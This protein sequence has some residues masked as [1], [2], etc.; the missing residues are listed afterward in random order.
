M[1]A[2]SS[3]HGN[4]QYPLP[5][6]VRSNDRPR[7][8]P[9]RQHTCHAIVTVGGHTYW[10]AVTR[11]EPVVLW[12]HQ[13]LLAAEVGWAPH[14]VGARVRTRPPFH[15]G[16]PA[17]RHKSL[18]NSTW[19]PEAFAG[20]W[21]AHMPRCM[22]GANAVLKAPLNTLSAQCTLTFTLSTLTGDSRQWPCICEGRGRPAS[23]HQ[24]AT[25]SDPC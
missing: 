16:T 6:F 20:S 15:H 9:R 18:I 5:R 3:R 23:A 19:S 1:Y 11:L 10:G 12:V 13:P 8:L 22:H 17:Q 24:A 25:A 14:R 4:R 7:H 2:S 21:A